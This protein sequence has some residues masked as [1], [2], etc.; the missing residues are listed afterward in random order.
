METS[1]SRHSSFWSDFMKRQVN[2]KNMT[3]FM[4]NPPQQGGNNCHALLFMKIQ[5][6]PSLKASEV[7]LWFVSSCWLL[8]ADHA[9]WTLAWKVLEKHHSCHMKLGF[10]LLICW[11]QKKSLKFETWKN[12]WLL[13]GKMATVQFQTSFSNLCIIWTMRKCIS[14]KVY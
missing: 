12:S 13:W 8:F 2:Y 1:N 3:F 6:F 11:S 14:R 9:I 7:L 10:P 4:N 5:L